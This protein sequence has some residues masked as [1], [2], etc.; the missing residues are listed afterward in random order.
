[1]I[2]ET[3][4]LDSDLVCTNANLSY[5]GL[6]IAASDVTLWMNGHTM[7]S[8][9]GYG[10]GIQV[11]AGYGYGNVQIRRGHFKDWSRAIDLAASDSAVLKVSIGQPGYPLNPATGYPNGTQISMVGDRNYLA[12]NFVDG[13]PR[14][15]L[16]DDLASIRGMALGGDDMYTWGNTFQDAQGIISAGDRQRHVL[17][18]VDGCEESDLADAYGISVRD[19]NGAVINRNVVRSCVTNGIEAIASTG[20]PGS[21]DNLGGALI[22]LNQVYSSGNDGIWA[23]DANAIVGRNTANDNGSFG[24]YSTRP[25]TTIQNNTANN[26]DYEGIY[27]APG[28]I[29]GGGNTATGNNQGGSQCLNV[30]CGTP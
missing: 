23:D 9:S 17:N 3:T 2:T 26:N 28:T 27:A 6:T 5:V 7:Q 29:D 25:G 19:Y 30:Q 11:P 4:V 10:T 8:T 14:R 12:G 24:I 15:Y 13:S 22:R 18:T 16:D 1:V 21:E 20:G